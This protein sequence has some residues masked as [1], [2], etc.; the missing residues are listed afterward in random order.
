VSHRRMPVTCPVAGCPAHASEQCGLR[1]RFMF[2]HPNGA[3]VISEES[4]LPKCESCR[5]VITSSMLSVLEPFNH[6]MARQLFRRFLCQS[7]RTP[8][9]ELHNPCAV[10]IC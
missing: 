10:S 7:N 1:Q 8:A 5:W 3:L 6:R 4:F 9:T 2:K